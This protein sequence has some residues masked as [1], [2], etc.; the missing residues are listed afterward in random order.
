MTPP[1]DRFERVLWYLCVYGL[2]QLAAQAG[3]LRGI[4]AK[5]EGVPTQ[6][7]TEALQHGMPHIFPISE[8]GYYDARDVGRYLHKAKAAAAKLRMSGRLPVSPESVQSRLERMAAE[9]DFNDE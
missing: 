3:V 2:H 4:M 1:A 6:A 7:I 5:Q 9:D 8:N